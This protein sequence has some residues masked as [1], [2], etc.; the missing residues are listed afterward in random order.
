MLFA[1]LDLE[2]SGGDACH[3]TGA[4]GIGKSSLLRL[5]ARL[6][7][8]YEGQVR[9]SGTVALLNDTSALDPFAPLGKSLDFWAK[10]DGGSDALDRVGLS[11]LADVPVRY[12]S[13]GQTKRAA[14][15]RMLAQGAAIWLL[16]EPLDGLDATAREGMLAEIERHR[17]EGGLSVIASHQPL[18]IEAQ[19]LALGDF[20]A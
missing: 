10:L 18:G 17:N 1:G 12:L 3:V 9:S 11:D 14:F 4:N 20:A 13:T 5:L 2:L 16:D 7:R 19:V 15:A 6:L 8:P